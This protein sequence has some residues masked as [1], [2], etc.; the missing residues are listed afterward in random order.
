M[1]PDGAR[2]GGMGVYAGDGEYSKCGEMKKDV[3]M[4]QQG[5]VEGELEAEYMA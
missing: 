1:T 2:D 3:K 4:V 5:V